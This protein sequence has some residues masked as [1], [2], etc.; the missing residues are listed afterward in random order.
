MNE[1]GDLFV[2]DEDRLMVNKLYLNQLDKE[3]EKSYQMN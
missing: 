3:I 1:H 2:S